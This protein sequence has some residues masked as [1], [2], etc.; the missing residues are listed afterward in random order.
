MLPEHGNI[1]SSPSCQTAQLPA[2]GR[3]VGRHE[4]V[5]Q[6]CKAMAIFAKA[7]WQGLSVGREVLGSAWLM[8]E[9]KG[10]NKILGGK[11]PGC[12]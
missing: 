11:V 6:V 7:A 1:D 9:P 4:V 10:R 3:E 2:S 12:Y 8:G 5:W